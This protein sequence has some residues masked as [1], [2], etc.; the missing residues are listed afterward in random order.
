MSKVLSIDPSLCTGCHRC[1]MWCSMTKYGEIN[2][3][4]SN[5]YVIRREPAVD[6]P[7]VCIQCGICIDVCPTGALKRDGSTDAVVVDADFC[8]GCGTCVKSCPY[9]VLRVDKETDVASKCDLCN[10]SPACASHCPQ[11]AIRYVEESEAA[12]KRRELWAKAFSGKVR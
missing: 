4:R 1:E 5:V 9:G 2:P 11:G 3:S 7:L 6:V 12:A 10:G 8:S